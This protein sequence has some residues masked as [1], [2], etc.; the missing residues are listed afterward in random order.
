M[1]WVERALPIVFGVLFVAG[2]VAYLVA[3]K[4]DW[5]K[6][7]RRALRKVADRLIILGCFGLLLYGLTYERIYVLSARIGYVLWFA[8]LVWYAWTMYR[9]VTVEMPAMEQRQAEREQKNKWL[10]K[11]KK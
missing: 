11:A 6:M 7:M 5:S 2:I 1:P 3:Y 4:R 8:L 9:L 10:P